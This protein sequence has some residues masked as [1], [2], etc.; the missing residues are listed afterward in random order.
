MA[1]ILLSGML[2]LPPLHQVFPGSATARAASGEQ[3]PHGTSPTEELVYKIIN[4]IILAG[5]LTFLLRKPLANFFAQRSEG[6]QKELEA[7]RKALED[8]RTRLES[9]EEKL[10]TVE[11]RWAALREEARK[12]DEIERLRLRQAAEAE[13][14]RILAAAQSQIESATRI[15]R[16]ELKHYAAEQAVQFATEILRQ[17]MTKTQQASLVDRFVTELS[18]RPK[19]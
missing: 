19:D 18:E 7:G 12:E 4:F 15:A 13:A 17:R 3:E 8:S 2:L 1:G 9:A 6:I 10:S 11:D 16:L 14:D 5:A